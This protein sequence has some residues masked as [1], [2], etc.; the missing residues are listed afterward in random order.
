M[1]KPKFQIKSQIGEVFPIKYILFQVITLQIHSQFGKFP[2][3]CCKPRVKSSRCY[4]PT[5]WKIGEFL[6]WQFFF[7]GRF[8][9]YWN[10]NREMPEMPILFLLVNLPIFVPIPPRNHRSE[11]PLAESENTLVRCFCGNISAQ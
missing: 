10:E 5:I 7:I 6:S 11:H 1:G 9:Q 2:T 3:L 4:E 8:H